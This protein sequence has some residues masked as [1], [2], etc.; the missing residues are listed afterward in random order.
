MP[1]HEEWVVSEGAYFCDGFDVF[2]EFDASGEESCAF[3]DHVEECVA[4]VVEFGPMV[5]HDAFGGFGVFDEV[6]VDGFALPLKL[7]EIE[8]DDVEF[9]ACFVVGLVHLAADVE[10]QSFQ[11]RGGWPVWP[12]NRHA[13]Q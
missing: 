9:R 5:G 1:F 13:C 3:V 7:F 10:M 2:G 4:F 8:Y 11:L 6:G 12:S